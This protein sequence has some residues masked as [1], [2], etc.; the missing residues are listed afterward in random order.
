MTRRQGRR[1]RRVWGSPRDLELWYLAIDR[2]EYAAY[3]RQQAERASAAGGK[4]LTGVRSV[5]TTALALPAGCTLNAQDEVP[6][7]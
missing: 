6:I 4:N 2:A 1:A 5:R 7:A 3:K